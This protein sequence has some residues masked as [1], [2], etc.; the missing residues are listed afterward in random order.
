M[1]LIAE[2]CQRHLYRGIDL[3][4]VQTVGKGMGD[5]THKGCDHKVCDRHEI[6]QGAQHLHR[7]GRHTN[8]FK[9]LA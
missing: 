7:F 2:E 4:A 9:G 1:S 5:D 6:V 3:G 8:L